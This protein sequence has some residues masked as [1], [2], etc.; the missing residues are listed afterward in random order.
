[1]SVLYISNNKSNLDSRQTEKLLRKCFTLAAE[2]VGSMRG[3]F[4][5]DMHE[6]VQRN[7]IKK[8]S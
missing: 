6:V 7:K 8:A 1:M 2:R 4:Q 3:A 5:G